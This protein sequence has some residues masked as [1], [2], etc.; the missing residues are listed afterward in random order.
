MPDRPTRGR[1][2][3]PRALSD[4]AGRR[5]GDP[6][7]DQRD[8]ATLQADVIAARVTRYEAG[9]FYAELDVMT[10]RGREVFDARTSD[11]IIL[12]LRQRVPAPILCAEEI[13]EALYL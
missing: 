3:A 11:A 1:G 12:A 2:P 5:P 7:A 10:P 4:I 8:P 6:R 9:V 13:L